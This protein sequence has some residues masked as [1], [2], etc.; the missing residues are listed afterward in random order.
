VARDPRSSRPGD[1]YSPPRSGFDRLFPGDVVS[2]AVVVAVHLVH[3]RHKSF[4]IRRLHS[5]VA[6]SN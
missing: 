1:G 2:G 5:K 4:G 6:L 3:Q